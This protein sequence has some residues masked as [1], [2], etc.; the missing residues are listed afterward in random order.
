MFALSVLAEGSVVRVRLDAAPAARAAR[1]LSG[2]R[3]S[4][5]SEGSRV[6]LPEMGVVEGDDRVARCW[7]SQADP[8]YQR[9]QNLE[10]GRPS[11]KTIACSSS[12]VS[13]RF[14]RPEL[15]RD[16]SIT[17]FGAAS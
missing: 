3:T 9:Y 10:W 2:R 17:L 11:G 12:S 6:E 14:T 4:A 15:A 13:R 5:G 8:V 1:H 7:W 16:P